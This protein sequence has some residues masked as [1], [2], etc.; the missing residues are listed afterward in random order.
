MHDLPTPTTHNRG[1]CVSNDDVLEQVR[2]SAHFIIIITEC[3]LHL[4]DQN[5]KYF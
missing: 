2:I 3:H 5:L 4:H 1:T